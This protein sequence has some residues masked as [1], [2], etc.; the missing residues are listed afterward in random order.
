[1]LAADFHAQRFGLEAIALAR[2][3]R[4]VGEVAGNLLARPIAVG[5]FETPLQ[6]GD[7]ALE[8]PLGVV[9]THAVVVAEA[10]LGLAGAVKDRLL[11]L[12]RQVLPLGIEGELVVLAERLQRLHVIG[13]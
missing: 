3:A 13:R 6:I 9:G 7:D 4:H 11:G 12:L 1:M 8:R 5:L 2:L 10:D